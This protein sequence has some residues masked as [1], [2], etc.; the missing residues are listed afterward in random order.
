MSS[1]M[2]TRVAGNLPKC[3][4]KRVSRADELHPKADKAVPKTVP[5]VVL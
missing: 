2:A 1:L 3:K 4:A 5:K